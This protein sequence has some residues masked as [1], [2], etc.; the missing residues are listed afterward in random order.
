MS[1]S[2]HAKI[3]NMSK[4]STTKNIDPT[5]GLDARVAKLEADVEHIKIDITEI[6]V[7]LRA[8]SARM[9]MQYGR[10]DDKIDNKIGALEKKI[11]AK[12]DTLEKKIDALEKRVD[13][14]I[15]ILEKKIDNLDHK[16]N[17]NTRW[18]VGMFMSAFLTS[19]GGLSLMMVHGFHWL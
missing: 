5:M 12:I 4:H 17:T 8:F 18:L 19:F 6:K 10:L 13:A 2:N 11:D 3:S 1:H 14:K 16:M 15:D 9:D 7:D